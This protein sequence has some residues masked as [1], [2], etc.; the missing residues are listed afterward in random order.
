MYVHTYVVRKYMAR[1][2]TENVI[3]RVSRLFFA[4]L[5]TH[6]MGKFNT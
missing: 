3:T 6:F 4:K 2:S 5:I 1:V